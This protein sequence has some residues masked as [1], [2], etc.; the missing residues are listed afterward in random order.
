MPCDRRRN[1]SVLS[2]R[3]DVKPAIGNPHQAKERWLAPVAIDLGVYHCP[4]QNSH[5]AERATLVPKVNAHRLGPKT[6]QLNQ[7]SQSH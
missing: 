3:L 4:I 5:R 7:I 2:Q 1:T 6:H